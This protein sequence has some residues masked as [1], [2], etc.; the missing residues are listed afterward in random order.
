MALDYGRSKHILGAYKL[1]VRYSYGHWCLALDNSLAG[2]RDGS[3]LWFG[4]K[5][6]GRENQDTYV[7]R[8]IAIST[9]ER[10]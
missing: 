4:L 8:T 5:T 10:Q 7:V 9:C 3:W 6:L 1:W 2:I